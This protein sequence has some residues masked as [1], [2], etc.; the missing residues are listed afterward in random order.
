MRLRKGQRVRLGLTGQLGLGTVLLLTPR[1]A[2]V[3]LDGPAGLE[4]DLPAALIAPL[5]EPARLDGRGDGVANV[6][7]ASPP[8]MGVKM[9]PSSAKTPRPKR[10]VEPAVFAAR[11]VVDAL[12]YG[13]VPTASIAEM[14][15]GFEELETWAVSRLP[16]ANGGYPQV[17]AIRG[18]FGTGKSHTMAVIR[19][20]A[21]SRGYLT[22]RVEADGKMISL[23]DPAQLLGSMLP[24]LDGN[25]HDGDHQL[26]ALFVKA[27]NKVAAREPLLSSCGR[28]TD[29]LATV[30]TIH[31][32]TQF[33][34]LE[35]W[36]ERL[37]GSDPSLT[38]NEFKNAVW[39]IDRRLAELG[40]DSGYRPRT[41]IAY[42]LAERP[43]SFS[44]SLMGIGTLARAAGYE[45]LV[46]T[47]D[48]FEVE[49]NLSN[50]KWQR[51]L[52][53]LRSL[54]AHV[55]RDGWVQRW[56][57]SIFVASV[58]HGEQLGA[59]LLDQVIELSGGAWYELAERDPG[60]LVTL[61]DR[62]AARYAAAY[63]IVAIPVDD[64]SQAAQARMS[65]ADRASSGQIRAFIRNTM[66][67]LDA[68]YGPPAVM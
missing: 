60:E 31:H 34:E 8:S 46:V 24:T 38:L 35:G 5:D 61:V 53:L 62:I 63:G 52:D 27:M 10:S 67:D 32:R 40:W 29:N 15:L 20:V 44:Q 47:I 2:L 58:E 55:S 48:E 22:V 33:D 64:V 1:G 59:A 66:A 26:T 21:R 49:S 23:S 3:R 13:V 28:I 50:D 68:R 11:R 41:M 42:R 65:A 6:G 17:S 57:V 14:T 9:A 36:I 4:L 39:A 43:D 30:K 7:A 54:I 19:D 25:G 18:A 51:V 56:P 37:L 12:R 45:G 16:P